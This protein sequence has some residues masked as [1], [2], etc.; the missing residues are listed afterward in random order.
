MTAALP[1][2]R[3]RRSLRD[4]ITGL[5]RAAVMAGEL[6]PGVVY[7]APSL[8][9][10]FGVSATPVREAMLDLSKEGLV[11]I[12]RNKGFRVARLSPKELDDVTELRALVEIPTVR[13]VAET[14]VPEEALARLRP[15]AAEIEEAARRRDFVAHVAIDLE[16]HLALLELAGNPRIVELVR[17]LRMHSRLYGLRDDTHRDAL[18]ASWHEHAELLDRI[19]A[20]DADGAEAV[21]RSHIGHVRGIWSER[22]QG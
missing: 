2:L 5:L 15:M 21:M 1:S 16:F 4:E 3:G 6:E 18:F 9:D 8:A 7:S 11:E 14:G 13:R 19:A 22:G 10:Q 12:V 17:S 20:R